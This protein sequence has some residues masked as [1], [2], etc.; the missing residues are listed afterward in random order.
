M[1][2]IIIRLKLLKSTAGNGTAVIDPTQIGTSTADACTVTNRW[3]DPDN[4]SGVSGPSWMVGGNSTLINNS[5]LPMGGPTNCYWTA[6]NCGPNDE[7][8]SF[9]TGGCHAAMADGSVRFL[10]QNM[11]WNVVR[12]LC[13][14]AGGE[15]GLGEF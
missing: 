14:A 10:S 1:S 2:S 5:Q 15:T 7:P 11:S 4:G 3:A 8:F 6:N 9:H 13:T 12:A